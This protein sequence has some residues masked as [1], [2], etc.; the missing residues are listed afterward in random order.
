MRLLVDLLRQMHIDHQIPDVPEQK[1][2]ML[3]LWCQSVFSLV[4]I[5]N[6]PNYYHLLF[7]KCIR[8]LF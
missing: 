4:I 6:L 8:S 3:A 1:T 7:L 5:A 2:F